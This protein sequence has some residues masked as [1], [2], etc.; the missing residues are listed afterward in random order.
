MNSLLDW[1]IQ[2]DT[3]AGLR[4]PVSREDA[5]DAAKAFDDVR[6][7][8][9]VRASPR[10][11]ETLDQIID[12]V[13]S[14][15]AQANRVSELEPMVQSAVEATRERYRETWEQ[16]FTT[17]AEDFY[18][19]TTDVLQEQERSHAHYLKQQEPSEGE[20]VP[21]EQ[22][23]GTAP[24]G[25]ATA[26]FIAANIGVLVGAAHLTTKNRVLAV[27]SE[28]IEEG[29]AEGLG[30]GQIIDRFLERIGVI[31]VHGES[32][33]RRIARTLVIRASN[34]AA[35][36]AARGDE[37]EW[38]KDW[39]SQ[40]DSRVRAAHLDTDFSGP[41]GLDEFFDVGGFQAMYP[42][43]PRLPPS[44]SLNCRCVIIFLR[45]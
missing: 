33:A 21:P 8:H 13:R 44:Q 15:A 3:L 18:L 38:E 16:E 26:T 2:N 1:K 9:I 10:I 14:S 11:E 28:V 20:P 6:Q 4:D 29:R 35:L 32:R 19:R 41:V 30:L 22:E 42:A 37:R 40:R 25:T 34:W 5:R 36:Q 39:V 23:P 12:D 7:S 45:A 31:G 27:L 17:V 24:I 43:D